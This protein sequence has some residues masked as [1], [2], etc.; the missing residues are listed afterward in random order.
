MAL[1]V[2]EKAREIAVRMWKVPPCLHVPIAAVNENAI[3]TYIGEIESERQ[4][5]AGLKAL[6]VRIPPPQP[7][8]TR[9]RIWEL[10]RSAE[11]FSPD[12]SGS[13]STTSVTVR[14]SRNCCQSEVSR[15]W[16]SVTQ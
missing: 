11:F 8:D 15:G 9:L 7:R 12:K 3:C 1:Q 16:C 13:I 10:P 2:D 5:R 14:P 6:L 4:N